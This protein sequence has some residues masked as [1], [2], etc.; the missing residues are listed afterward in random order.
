MKRLAFLL[1][2]YSF[3]CAQSVTIAPIVP[4]HLP[5]GTQLKDAKNL[6]KKL[7]V[8]VFP[9]HALTPEPNCPQIVKTHVIY[10]AMK[11]A[12]KNPMVKALWA[13]RGGRMAHRLWPLLDRDTA[14]F[15]KGPVLVGFSDITSLH[16]WFNEHHIPTLHALVLAHAKE[17]SKKRDVNVG[18]S[19]YPVLRILKGEVK[20]LQYT[21]LIPVN[22][23]ARSHKAWT[24]PLM[25]TTL[26]SLHYY[27]SAYG[28]LK[29]PHIL[30]I[31]TWDDYTRSDSIL[32]SLTQA[33]FFKNTRAIILGSFHGKHPGDRGFKAAQGRCEKIARYFA[34]TLSIPVFR[35]PARRQK[36]TDLQFGHGKYNDP[37]PLG[38]WAKLDH[39]KSSLATLSI[40]VTGLV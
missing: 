16:L 7:G 38:T 34:D 9:W 40:D 36:K 18:S 39:T 25:G 27:Q 24:G 12:W 22:A 14:C 20:S 13:V 35:T 23:A 33:G 26:S 32:L 31:E 2:F 28:A 4:S 6:L 15:K 21:G 37:L 29:R 11:K 17:I 3:A 8:R 10:Q 19:A 5:I 30:L 1:C